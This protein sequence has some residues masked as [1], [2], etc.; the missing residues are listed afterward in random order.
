MSEL[1]RLEQQVVQKLL[2]G[3]SETLA[4][5]RSQ[6]SAC[7]AVKREMTGVGFYVNLEVP[8]TVPRVTR[9]SFKL[10]D[11]NA[12][13]EGLKHGAGFLLYVESGSLVMLEGYTYDEPWP[14]HIE[15]FELSYDKVQRD[16]DAL[17]KLWS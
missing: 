5:L 16:W 12:A 7:R 4:N 11:V 14:E 8:A 1:T 13:I 6:L 9:S 17:K 2:S 3:E 10:G 15:S